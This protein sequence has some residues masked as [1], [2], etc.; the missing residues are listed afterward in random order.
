MK[1]SFDNIRQTADLTPHLEEVRTKL[2]TVLNLSNADDSY[3]RVTLL[4]NSLIRICLI[5]GLSLNVERK[6]EE[7][8]KM[9]MGQT[10]NRI[11]SS[12]F[13]F[14]DFAPLFSTLIKI[15]YNGVGLDLTDNSTVSR[16]I[17]LEAERGCQYLLQE[18]NLGRILALAESGTSRTSA[19]PA[20]QLVIGDYGENMPAKLDI[21]GRE[22]NNTQIIVA[23]ATGSG[24]TNLLMVLISQMRAL[25]VET[26]YPVNFLLFDY[27]GEFSDPANSSWLR[28][29]DV[30]TTSLLNP[31]DNPLPFSP[32]KDF[33]N[34]PINEINLYSTEMSGALASIDR[35]NISANMQNRLSTAI[36]EA[37]KKTSGKPITFKMILDEYRIRM[38][39]K[40]QDDSITAVLNQLVT[41][42]IFSETDR[43]NLIED[44]YIIDMSRYPKDGPIAKAI[45][46]FTISKLN[47]IYE[48]LPK[49]ETNE[50]CVQIRHFTII[51]E[52]HYMLDFDN[53]PLRNLIAV[54]RNKGMSI[55]LATQDMASF[56]S[57][58]FDYYTNAQYP[59]IMKQQTIDNNV[60]KDLF[61]ASAKELQDIRAAIAGLQKGELI[62]K[63][64]DAFLLGIGQKYKKIKVTHLI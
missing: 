58:Y 17:G 5:A 36:V 28:L 48:N 37:Y 20:L 23:G 62:I 12:V 34:S 49:Q 10:G 52:A 6:A 56:K 55:I 32:F 4:N 59:L 35:T 54:G 60:I 21:N 25:S 22:I 9:S 50:T 61:G 11:Y 45:V 13:S 24:K 18:D 27:K 57:R 47:I 8:N 30:D 7:V 40:V 14:S 41:N 1:I 53:R 33:S 64:Q 42:N 19:I 39:E 63:N 26:P 43:V 2:E 51:D 31:I 46:Y 38:K 15:R 3:K 16:I 44:S 29:M